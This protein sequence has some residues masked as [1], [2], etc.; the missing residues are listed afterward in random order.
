MQN[1]RREISQNLSGIAEEITEAER[2]ILPSTDWAWMM[3]ILAGGGHITKNGRVLFATRFEQLQQSLIERGEKLFQR[4]ARLELYPNYPNR[5][6]V[7]AFGNKTVALELSS[8]TRDQ[9]VTTINARHN[10]LLSDS[11]YIWPF[12]EGVFEARGRFH[13]NTNNRFEQIFLHSVFLKET[14]F[15]TEL[16]TRVG[17][18]DPR[19]IRARM[20]REGVRGVS[21]SLLTDIRLFSENVHSVIPFKEEGLA[22]YRTI[23]TS[24]RKFRVYSKDEVISDWIKASV[25]LKRTPTEH[26]IRR[27]RQLGIIQCSPQVF[28]RLFSESGS[29]TDFKNARLAL[30][31]IFEESHN[32]V[33]NDSEIEQARTKFL[34]AQWLLKKQRRMPKRY[35]DED[36][37]ESWV[38]ARNMLGYIPTSADLE[39]LNEEGIVKITV[40]TFVERFGDGRTFVSARNS[41]EARMQQLKETVLEPKPKVARVSIKVA[42]V[43]ITDE[44]LINEWIRLLEYLGRIPSY[45]DIGRLL[46]KS[47]TKYSPS[48]YKKRFGASDEGV[49]FN[50]AR[51]KL[52]ELSRSSIDTQNLKMSSKAYQKSLTNGEVAIEW[53]RIRRILGHVPSIPELS[54]LLT[55]ADTLVSPRTYADRF[56]SSKWSQA[57][58]ALERIV[59]SVDLNE[60]LVQ[61]EN[62][63]REQVRYIEKIHRA[64][65]PF[66]DKYATSKLDEIFKSTQLPPVLFYA[67]DGNPLILGEEVSTELMEKTS[68]SNKPKNSVTLYGPNL[69]SE[70]LTVTAPEIPEPAIIVINQAKGKSEVNETDELIK[71]SRNLAWILGT[72]AAGGYVNLKTGYIEVS[73]KQPVLDRFKES[74]LNI[75]KKEI[76]FHSYTHKGSNHPY[77][78]ARLC[79]VDFA[80]SIGDL[81]RNSWSNTINSRHVWIKDESNE[82]VWSFLEG[83]FDMR[84]SISSFSGRDQ[85]TPLH[86]VIYLSTT[87]SNGTN[88]LLEMLG[89]VGIDNAFI[90]R[91]K[92]TREGVRGVVISNLEDVRGIAEHISSSIPDKQKALENCQNRF[93]HLSKHFRY[94]DD[95]LKSDWRML[96]SL[97][98]RNPSSWDLRRDFQEA[99]RIHTER[100]YAQRFGNG[101][102]ATARR[103]LEKLLESD[104]ETM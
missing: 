70:L 35:S 22:F 28:G 42:R 69:N 33:F 2:I 50:Q 23:D 15:L 96:A 76:T 95:E 82:Y 79:S 3:G 7:I 21:M 9:Y 18:E 92:N 16:L 89:S 86:P 6:P 4:N 87:S 78:R 52:L 31:K 44:A 68:E 62:N 17:V 1:E 59:F 39:R 73:G 77:S 45:T 55:N 32:I 53:V 29:P 72:L 19:V 83:F 46:G 98:D 99:I 12:L 66:I 103:N 5:S 71:P 51:R 91:S 93:P 30:E 74:G 47:E 40:P 88:A 43:S 14:S 63:S 56:G 60:S 24:L 84:G 38:K 67:H 48:T 20:T 97:L 49:S 102:F 65:L 10:W 58:S 100:T 90:H 26:Y 8:F 85:T 57:V 36:I 34:E 94:T 104:S 81:R 80:R 25:I 37:I 64:I 41:L 101:N 27:L 11:K 54:R 61:Y 75:F 13:R